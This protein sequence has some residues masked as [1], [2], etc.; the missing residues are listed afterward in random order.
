MIHLASAADIAAAYNLKGG[1]A[2]YYGRCP[3]HDG[4]N[5]AGL[6]VL[7]RDR[8]VITCHT[9]GCDWQTDILPQLR[10][11]GLAWIESEA[12]ANYQPKPRRPKETPQPTQQDT[13][14]QA[15]Q[16][17]CMLSLWRNATPAKFTD[18][19]YCQRKRV[20]PDGRLRM[21]GDALLVPLYR[22]GKP[23]TLQRIYPDGTKRM[24]PGLPFKGAYN[25]ISDLVTDPIYI[26]E[27]WAT[28]RSIYDDMINCMVVCAMSA[29]NLLPVATYFKQQYPDSQLIIAGDN[30]TH[31]PSSNGTELAISAARTVGCDFVMPDEPGD[32]NDARIARIA[33]DE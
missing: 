28:G 18:S 31:N 9:A 14:R 8:P 32:F 23:A 27:G 7:D 15:R 3:F 30:D 33:R 22:A 11:D 29:N 10:A 5:P 12:K 26:C 24:F 13:D 25:V 16:Y 6:S 20:S 21:H 1:P 17:Q 4:D 19:D 2:K